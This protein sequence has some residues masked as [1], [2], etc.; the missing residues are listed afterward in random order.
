MHA[1]QHPSASSRP[2]RYA[3]LLAAL[4]LALLALLAGC[5]TGST[6]MST[7]SRDSAPFPAG[8]DGLTQSDAMAKPAATANPTAGTGN[9]SGSASRRTGG[10]EPATGPQQPGQKL[11][12]QAALSL[13]VKDVAAAAAEVRS[14]ATGLGGTITS[15][16]LRTNGKPDSADASGVLIVSVPAARLDDALTALGKVGTVEEQSTSTE[17]VTTTYTDTESRLATMRASVERVRALM[18]QATKIGDIV[19]LEGELST[20]Q[21]DLESLEAQLAALKGAVAQ[22]PIEIRLVTDR[23]ALRSVQDTGFVAGLKAGWRAFTASVVVVLTALGAMLPFLV[24]L[25]VVVLPLLWLLRRRR[26]THDAGVVSAPTPRGPAG[27]P[28]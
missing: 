7:E 3:G 8:Q 26:R 14:V 9:T 18:A 13:T 24:V 1:T 17:D 6:S 27:P 10:I 4:A 22:S 15:E 19:A 12:R 16:S 28:A 25:A 2:N 5:S 11:T 21:A 20:R 23:S